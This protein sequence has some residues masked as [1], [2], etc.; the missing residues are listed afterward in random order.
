MLHITFLE[1]NI[2]LSCSKCIYPFLEYTALT[3]HV[4]LMP[5]RFNDNYDQDKISAQLM[6]ES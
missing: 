2:T 6:H 5:H 4:L 3:N 1:V